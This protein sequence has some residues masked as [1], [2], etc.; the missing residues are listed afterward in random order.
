MTSRKVTLLLT[1]AVIALATVFAVRNA[2]TPTTQAPQQAPALKTTEIAV[3]AHDLPT[4]SILKQS[5]IKWS[6]WI[7]D[8][9]TGAFF[10][11]DK[12]DLSTLAG[13]VVRDGFRA[14]DPILSARIAHAHDQGFLAAVLTPGMR[15]MSLALSPT[16]EVA[17]F[18]FPGDRVDVILTRGFSRKDVQSLTER[19]IS[20]TILQNVRV[21]ALDQRS[22]NHE[23]TPKV[24]QIATLE[25][26][27]KDAEKLALAIDL[28]D[29]RGLSGKASLTLVLRS[30]ALDPSPSE[31]AQAAPTWDSDVSRS[32]PSMNGS[33]SL[34]HRVQV[35]RGKT[36]TENFFERQR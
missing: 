14:G 33:D 9:D 29:A 17:G 36:T 27:P 1:A 13:A 35:M 11:K 30:L 25:V 12:D 4:G 23:N 5:D 10:V 26:S 3:A 2:T 34:V 22:S 20:E 21:L 32:Y 7:A 31:P 6:P 8:A 15:A 19:R 28:A 16:A 18:I 24:A